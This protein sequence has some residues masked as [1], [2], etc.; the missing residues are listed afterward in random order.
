MYRHTYPDS[1]TVGNCTSKSQA[2]QLPAMQTARNTTKEDAETIFQEIP[3]LP[4]IKYRYLY[5]CLSF[6]IL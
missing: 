6:L 2:K 3:K 1:I 5:Y 4:M